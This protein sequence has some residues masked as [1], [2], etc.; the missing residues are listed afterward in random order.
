ML[1][2]D[3]N[4]LP[5]GRTCRAAPSLV[6]AL[7]EHLIGNAV[8]FCDRGDR[9]EVRER[10]DGQP[11][12]EV[13]DTGPGVAPALVP[14]LFRLDR[15][16]CSIGS[17]GETGVGM[18]LALYRALLRILGGDLGWR[19]ADVQPEAGGADPVGRPGSVFL[20]RLPD[21]LAWPAGGLRDQPASGLG[22]S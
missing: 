20:V 8:K 15:A 19:S 2:W 11:G 7:L 18:S 10:D 12:F 4:R 17:W 22:S 3:H 14:E 16:G 1:A 13:V 9:V 6:D 5:D 21:R